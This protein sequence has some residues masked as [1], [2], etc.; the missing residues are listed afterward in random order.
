MKEKD[1]VYLAGPYSGDVLKNIQEAR[2]YALHLWIHG[3]AVICPH[4]NTAHFDCFE[5][6]YGLDYET[7]MGGDFAFIERVDAVFVMPGWESSSGTRREIE[8]AET[9]EKP[10][11]YLSP[12]EEPGDELVF[13]DAA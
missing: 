1:V 6:M 7:W 5:G 9:L 2:K 12:I 13:R 11:Y 8:L 3:Y 10:V 4:M